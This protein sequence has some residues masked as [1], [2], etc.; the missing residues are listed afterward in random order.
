MVEL[1]SALWVLFALCVF[2]HGLCVL[3]E[4][5]TIVKCCF[6]A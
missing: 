2:V 1:H 5:P 6:Y 3:V 4:V